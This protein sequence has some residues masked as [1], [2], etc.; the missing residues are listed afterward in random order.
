LRLA[1]N[2]KKNI[3]VICIDLILTLGYVDFISVHVV[4]RQCLSISGHNVVIDVGL[5]ILFL[6]CA[7]SS[8]SFCADVFAEGDQLYD[9]MIGL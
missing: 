5:I 9:H 6:F 4:V 3:S 8:A 1:K 7:S 2:K